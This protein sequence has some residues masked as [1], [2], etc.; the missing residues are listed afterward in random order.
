MKKGI[1]SR[2]IS[3]LMEHFDIRNESQLAKLIGMP[4]TTVNKL[5]SGVSADPRIST[6]TPIIDHFKISLDTL[7]SESPTFSSVKTND[8][9]DLLIP[10]I[11]YDELTDMYG[12]LHSLNTTNWPHWFPIPKQENDNYYS[13][14]L[15]AQQLLK[16]FNET[17]LLI[18]HNSP[19]LE[20]NTYCVVKHLSSNSINVKKSFFENG[21]E[22]LLALQSELPASEFNSE[23][24]LLL[25]TIQACVTDMT[26]GDFIRIGERE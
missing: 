24:W 12:D 4:Q 8:A 2:N 15:T 1:I 25:G 14:H 16:P 3:L 7:L 26:N 6:L 13:I 17:S 22:W 21:K 11:T 18:I 19:K 20:N 23:E 10:L 9:T 5:I